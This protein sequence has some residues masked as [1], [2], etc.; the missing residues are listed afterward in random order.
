M[1]KDFTPRYVKFFE[2]QLWFADFIFQTWQH[3]FY[4]SDKKGNIFLEGFSMNRVNFNSS[5]KGS[6]RTLVLFLL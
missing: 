4:K 1:A 3:K 2:V 6:L 5:S